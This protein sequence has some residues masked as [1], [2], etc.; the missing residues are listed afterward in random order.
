MGKKSKL[1]IVTENSL[2]IIEG[3]FEVKIKPI[4][5]KRPVFGI[6]KEDL[7]NALYEN[8]NKRHDG[9]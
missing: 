7:Y 6:T 1:E 3:K 4:E 8:I 5:Q 9:N 2:F